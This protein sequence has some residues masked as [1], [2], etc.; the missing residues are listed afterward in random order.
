MR[1]SIQVFRIGVFVTASLL[2]TLPSSFAQQQPASESDGRCS[3][4][5]TVHRDS[6]AGVEHPE[7]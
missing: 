3:H 2:F 7:E 1:T 6:E 5:R 4:A